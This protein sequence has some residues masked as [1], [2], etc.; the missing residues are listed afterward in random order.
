MLLAS[1]DVRAG[2]PLLR[3][4]QAGEEKENDEGGPHEASLLIFLVRRRRPFLLPG[5]ILFHH[6][7]GVV[8]VPTVAGASFPID[9]SK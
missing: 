4:E 9:F 6:T 7:C 8:G 3:G 2:L 5:R 1:L